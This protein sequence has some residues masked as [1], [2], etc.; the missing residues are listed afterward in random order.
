[1]ESVDKE[2]F[3]VDCG[4]QMERVAGPVF[5]RR[6]GAGTVRRSA[7]RIMAPLAV[8]MCSLT[9]YPVACAVSHCRGVGSRWTSEDGGRECLVSQARLTDLR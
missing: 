4:S 7:W 9:E 1:M 5:A 2:V 6:G 3:V 8:K